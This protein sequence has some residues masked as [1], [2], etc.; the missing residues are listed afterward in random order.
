MQVFILPSFRL[1]IIINDTYSSSQHILMRPPITLPNT[2]PVCKNAFYSD[3]SDLVSHSFVFVI[4][5]VSWSRL[6][7][8]LTDTWYNPTHGMPPFIFYV[9]S[10][11]RYQYSLHIPGNSRFLTCRGRRFSTQRKQTK[12]CRNIG[13]WRRY[14]LMKT[15]LLMI[16]EIVGCSA[17]T[18]MED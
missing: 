12:Y 5:P 9:L 8:T 6:N 2:G 15:S 10:F 3:D 11:I 18:D 16:P 4:S 7:N 13:D 1:Y 17:L 14:S